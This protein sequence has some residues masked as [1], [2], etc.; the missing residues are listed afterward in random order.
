M[1][2]RMKEENVGILHVKGISHRKM[3]STNTTTM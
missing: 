2:I 1:K 3:E